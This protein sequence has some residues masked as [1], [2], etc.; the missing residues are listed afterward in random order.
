MWLR[1]RHRDQLDTPVETTLSGEQFTGLLL[2]MQALR[3]WPQSE[4]FPDSEHR[5]QAP[6]WIADQTE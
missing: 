6:A 4:Q 2:Y 1:E 3:D 5:P